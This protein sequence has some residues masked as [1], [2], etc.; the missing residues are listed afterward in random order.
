MKEK[1]ILSLV[2][3]SLAFPVL[4]DS[5]STELP[6]PSTIALFVSAAIAVLLA[7]KFKK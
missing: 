4:A 2:A 3:L 5:S 1:V 6:E 7:K